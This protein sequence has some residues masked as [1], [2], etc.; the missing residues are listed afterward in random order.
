MKILGVD[1]GSSRTG[2]VL[3]TDR[4]LKLVA[5]VIIDLK[6]KSL[7]QKI[8]KLANQY[9]KI[10][11]ELRPDLVA[12]EKIFF[13]KNTKTAIEVAQA[14]GVL[15]YLTVKNKIGCTEYTPMQVKQSITNYGLADKKAV[16]K[17]VAA[18]LKIEPIKGFDDISDAIA[19]AITAC[20][21]Y[22]LDKEN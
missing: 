1:P 8:L 11:T 13:A 4:P 6:E 19:I 20:N 5:S 14:R 9:E 12:I 7:N 21:F 3:I 10:L 2:Y 16:I 17:M 15:I 22:S 18:I